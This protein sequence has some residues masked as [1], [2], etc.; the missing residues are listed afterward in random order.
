MA[1]VRSRISVVPRL[2]C[3]AVVFESWEG[4]HNVLCLQALRDM[5]RYGLHESCSL[6]WAH[7]LDRVTQSELSEPQ[8][9]LLAA[10]RKRGLRVDQ[11]VTGASKFQQTHARRIVD[12]LSAVIQ[13]TCLL[14][15]AG[16]GAGAG[17]GR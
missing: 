15:E 3:D 6:I 2:Y 17:T 14:A 11:V 8:D 7:W 4:S 5:Q 16:L 10:Y 1:M 9:V 13:A 12:E